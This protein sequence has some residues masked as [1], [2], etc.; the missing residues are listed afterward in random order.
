M[1]AIV[2]RTRI[3][4]RTIERPGGTVVDIAAK[5]EAVELAG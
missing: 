2:R 4:Q 1:L 5:L 3:F